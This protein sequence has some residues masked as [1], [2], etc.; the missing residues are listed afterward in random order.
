MSLFLNSHSYQEPDVFVE[1]Q[2]KGVRD[3]LKGF[4]C[5]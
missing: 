1:R 4:E 2:A 5:R 3:E